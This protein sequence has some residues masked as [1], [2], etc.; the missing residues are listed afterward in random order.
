MNLL[1]TAGADKSG[2]E[3]LPF[4][5]PERGQDRAP[6]L[7]WESI[8]ALEP[9]LRQLEREARTSHRRGD[10]RHYESLKARLSVLVGHRA[11][12]PALATP[13]AFDICHRRLV[14]ALR[15]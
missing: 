15:V 14:E 1:N 9:R 6:N 11:R 7:T 12:L 8:I 3:S 10:W 4:A 2:A 13:E 5:G